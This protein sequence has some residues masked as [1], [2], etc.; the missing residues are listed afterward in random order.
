L[1]LQ[2]KLD[3][4][5]FDSPVETQEP[6]STLET[7]RD[8]LL[9]EMAWMAADFEVERNAPRVRDTQLWHVLC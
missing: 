3:V 6:S 8:F 7:H 2:R 5:A 4:L 1:E 9:K